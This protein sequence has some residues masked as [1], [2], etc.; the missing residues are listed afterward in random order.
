MSNVSIFEKKWIDLVFEGKN[1]EYGAYQLRRESP[2]TTLRAFF[3]GIFSIVFVAGIGIFFSSF[4]PTPKPIPD[5]GIYDSIIVVNVEPPIEKKK[6]NKK[7]EEHETESKPAEKIPENKKPIVVE[8]KE[9]DPI[10]PKNDDLPKTNTPAGGTENGIGNK[11]TTPSTGNPGGSIDGEGET[12]KPEVEVIA[13]VLD[14]QP[15]FPGGIKK[16]YQYVGDNFEKQEIDEVESITV[17]VSFVI[18]KDGSMSD[19]KVLRNPGYGLDKEAIRVLK[20]L[21]TKWKPGVLNGEFVRTRYNLPIT[22]KVN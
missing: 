16:F 1:K 11:P 9:A 18:E 6:N 8:T 19:I 5:D 20:S 17:N 2:R 7:I 10:V 12:K 15:E 4:G 3:F 22:V 21:R 14:A 13:A